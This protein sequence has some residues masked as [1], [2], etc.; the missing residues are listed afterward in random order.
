MELFGTIQTTQNKQIFYCEKCQYKT[1]WK[2]NYNKHLLTPKHNLGSFGNHWKYESICTIKSHK[3]DNCNNIFKTPS[4][5]WKHKKKCIKQTIITPDEP[6]SNII[7]D[8]IK[9]NQE[10]KELL[11]EQSKQIIQLSS[12]AANNCTTITTNNTNINNNNKF[13]LHFFLNETCKDALNLTDFI[14]SLK[15]TMSDFEHFGT[16]GFVEGISR[17]FVKGLKEL[18][19]SK[20]PIHCTDLKRE[21][22]YLKEKNTWEKDDEE[23][24]KIKKAI[25]SIAYKNT[26]MIPEWKQAN[27]SCMDG[28]SKKN[29]QYMKILS[30]SMGPSTKE[31]E[32]A[33]CNKI[34]KN[35]LKEVTIVK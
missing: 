12:V 13:N 20:R 2:Q 4:G 3:C 34:I 30:E 9:Q 6:C 16:H 7:I 24:N 33:N 25:K 26:R 23:R 28:D 5:L 8:L 19:V 31:E 27:P 17:I 32:D 29:T 15:I 35:I 14:D 18:D 11:L 1:I 22:I 21:V 10:F